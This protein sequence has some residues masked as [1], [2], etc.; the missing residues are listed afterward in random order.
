MEVKSKE[1][2]HVKG[3]HKLVDEIDPLCCLSNTQ[4]F[5][6]TDT[7]CPAKYPLSRFAVFTA[8]IKIAADFFSFT[9]SLLQTI[10]P[11]KPFLYFI[12]ILT[13]NTYILDNEFNSKKGVIH[14]T[15][16]H[17][18]A[19]SF[20]LHEHSKLATLPHVSIFVMSRDERN[21]CYVIY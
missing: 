15:N 5:N 17:M 13:L 9:K 19:C 6:D 21:I 7:F 1:I 10:K 18:S 16:A 12:L 4:T 11:E 20:S 14:L 3:V 8:D 2:K